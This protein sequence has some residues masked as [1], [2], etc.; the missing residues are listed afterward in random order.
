MKKDLLTRTLLG[1]AL[2]L[3]VCQECAA[4]T[5]TIIAC[6]CSL[7]VSGFKT[8]LSQV[9][10]DKE[11]DS[12]DFIDGCNVQSYD[13]STASA[14]MYC[15]SRGGNTFT[16]Y[17]KLSLTV[18]ANPIT[19]EPSQLSNGQTTEYLFFSTDAPFAYAFV[20]EVQV[21]PLLTNSEV[22]LNS[23]LTNWGGSLDRSK[24]GAAGDYTVFGGNNN[25]DSVP[26]T[27]TITWFWA[28]QLTPI[29]VPARF[30]AA[31]KSAFYKAFK[32]G[33]AAWKT[34]INEAHAST[35]PHVGIPLLEAA[36]RQETLDDQL[37]EQYMDPLD[38]NYTALA[39]VVVPTVIPLVAG[40]NITQ[41]EAD[42]YNAWMTNLSQSAA[43]GTAF[44]TSIN[45]A[46][47]AASAGNS[48]WETAQM[49]AA[50]QFE[51]QLAAIMDQEPALRSNV[52]AQFQSDEFAAITVTTNDAVD[53][54]LEI[55]TNGLPS[56]L[57]AGLTELGADGGT[58][59]NIQGELLTSDPGTIVGNFPQSFINTNLDS[60]QHAAAAS[61][62][63]ASL[64]L[65]NPARLPNGLFRFDLPTEPGYT[66]TIQFTQNPANPAP[67]TA[68]LTTNA[69]T[70]LLSFT[71]TPALGAQAGFYQATH[72]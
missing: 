34:E 4:L 50:V 32:A 1:I 30:T 43:V 69:T 54:Q 10:T 9:F 2:A 57:L 23:Q 44:S 12:P 46:Q 52:V 60:T 47:G 49:G 16:G 55:A 28:L 15:I 42:V 36:L 31:Q 24:T 14:A 5:I 29:N 27:G 13:G 59:T 71:N 48:S 41:L 8:G 67:W 7:G 18:G 53:L 37:F 33:D 40:N 11:V 66:Y 19:E 20:S 63:D 21:S 61:L 39:Q 62:R 51:A 65:I 22:D 38:T 72:N 64:V 26:A 58:I 6:A 35:D 3:L 25:N 70:A 68:L 56:D 45:R 17:G